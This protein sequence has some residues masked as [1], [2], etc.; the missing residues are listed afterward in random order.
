MLDRSLFVRFLNLCFDLEAGARQ[1]ASQVREPARRE[2][3]QEEEGGEGSGSRE[4]PGVPG[5]FGAASP[6]PG[7]AL[8]S[9]G[10]GSYI[11]SVHSNPSP[12]RPGC[13]GAEAPPPENAGGAG[14]RP[15]A[16]GEQ[17]DEG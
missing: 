6:A 1:E 13:V 8:S 12:F 10:V 17:E 14:A 4:E 2:G 5:R 7:V 15:G 9:A 16:P 11:T 3:G